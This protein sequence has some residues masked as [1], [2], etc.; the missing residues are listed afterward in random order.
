MEE[1]VI[2]LDEETGEEVEFFVIEEVKINNINYILVT[3]SDEEEADAYILKEVNTSD[4]DSV[5]EMVTDDDEIEYIGKVFA[6]SLD[7][8]ITL[9]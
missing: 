3:D 2:F 4:E 6:Q 5:L 7:E 1:T 8:E 9:Q